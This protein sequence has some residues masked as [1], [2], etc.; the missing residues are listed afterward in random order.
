MTRIFIVDDHNIVIEG[1]CAL[2]YGEPEFE[3]TGYAVNG[4]NCLVYLIA[5]TVDVV[6]LDISLPDIGG[7]D[8]CR[9]IKTKYPDTMVLALTTF[10]QGIYVRKMMESGASGYLLKDTSRQEFITAIQTVAQGKIYLS[11][12]AN[13]ALQSDTRQLIAIPT[14]TK[15]EK[16]VLG[17]VAKGLTNAQIAGQLSISID[18]VDSHRKNLHS[19]L[20]VKNTAQLVRYAVE[21]N[22]L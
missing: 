14:L 10:N 13:Q 1:I 12:M 22:L 15:R 8:L 17:Y 4:N 2:L 6:L 5:H 7:V 19:K 3:V 20:N 11:P 16:E 18:T 21:N 9:L